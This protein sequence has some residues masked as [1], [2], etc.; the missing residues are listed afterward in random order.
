MPRPRGRSSCPWSALYQ[1][2]KTIGPDRR[3]QPRSGSP[4]LRPSPSGRRTGGRRRFVLV[5]SCVC[6]PVCRFCRN[7]SC[8]RSRCR[9]SRRRPSCWTESSGCPVHSKRFLES[10]LV[11]DVCP[12]PAAKKLKTENKK[13]SSNL[14]VSSIVFCIL[15]EQFFLHKFK[16]L[17]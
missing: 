2:T 5:G 7:F 6:L 13:L 15:K 9:S 11:G 4:R 17:I 14:E 16:W 12:L 10:G 8:S 3:W 1:V